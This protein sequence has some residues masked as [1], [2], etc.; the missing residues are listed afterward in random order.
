MGAAHQALAE[1]G[2]GISSWGSSSGDVN[3]IRSGTYGGHYYGGLCDLRAGVDLGGRAAQGA[4]HALARRFE[5]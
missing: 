3:F 2:A 4:T 1:S 5:P